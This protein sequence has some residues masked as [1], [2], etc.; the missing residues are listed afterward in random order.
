MS[1]K[2]TLVKTKE[3][4]QTRGINRDGYYI[5]QKT[6]CEVCIEG[7]LRLATGG[8]VSKLDTV[9][10][11][12]HGDSPFYNYDGNSMFYR[13]AHLVLNDVAMNRPGSPTI[14]A[15]NDQSQTDEEIYEFL[16][17]AIARA[18]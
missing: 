7:A 5:N 9:I 1:V 13:L 10:Q 16:D 6:G 8:R 18:S 11:V 14:T 4:L 12:E 17:E 3:I 2:E 15:F